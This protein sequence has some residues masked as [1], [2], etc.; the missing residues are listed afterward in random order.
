MKLLLGK[1][2]ITFHLYRNSDVLL[3][4]FKTNR[5]LWDKKKKNT[6]TKYS[7]RMWYISFVFI[8]VALIWRSSET[9]DIHLKLTASL[10]SS[11]S[12]HALFGLCMMSKWNSFC[13][14]KESVA[15]FYCNIPFSVFINCTVLLNFASIVMIKWWLSSAVTFHCRC[16]CL[17]SLGP[18]TRWFLG[19]RFCLS[20]PKAEL[21]L[22]LHTIFWS[23]MS[24]GETKI[25]GF[26]IWE[27]TAARR[28]LVRGRGQFS[29]PPWDE[30][31]LI[32]CCL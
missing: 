31:Q 1:L 17:T 23:F 2:C 13:T 12:V 7:S 15:I 16:C 24:T 25:V 3:Y 21:S 30:T 26:S 28:E 22:Y 6:T 19:V 27:T 8:C 10:T 20:G 11:T 14:T 18:G 4:L 29:Q 9:S 5:V 32:R